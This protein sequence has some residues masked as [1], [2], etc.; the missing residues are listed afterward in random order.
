MTTLALGGYADWSSVP[1][2]WPTWWLGDV[3][4]AIIVTPVF[5]LWA[6]KPRVRWNRARVV[7][8]SVVLACL[9]ATGALVF[10]GWIPHAYPFMCVPPIIWI[11]FRLGTR[12]TATAVLVLSGLALSGTLRGLGPFAQAPPDSA[13]LLLQGFV[14]IMGLTALTLAAAVTERAGIERLLRKSEEEHRAIAALTTDFAAISRFD[15]GRVVLESVTDGFSLVTGYT[16]AELELRGGWPALMHPEDRVTGATA[17]GDF[18]AGGRFTGDLR[19]VTKSGQTRW[20]RYFSSPFSDPGEVGTS[21]QRLLTAVQD[22]TDLV[23][24]VETARL[25]GATVILSGL[26]AGITKRLVAI[27]IDV[28]RLRTAGDLQA[29]LDEAQRLLLPSMPK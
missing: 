18:F 1:S 15:D 3:A 12:E 27:G 4:G 16:H 2:I 25:M 24:T 20:L 21:A 26:S 29:G 23:Q 10:G 13:L 9:V 7:E 11:A 17:S 8:V 22:I 28:S 14:G 19:I 6:A 5:V